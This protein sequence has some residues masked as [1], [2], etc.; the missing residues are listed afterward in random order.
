[1]AYCAPL[2][3]PHSHFT[4]WDPLDQAKAL[5]FQRREAEKCPSC[6]IHPEV[7]DPEH[8]GHPDALRLMSVL[9]RPC[10]IAENSRERFSKD[11][12]AGERQVFRPND[13]P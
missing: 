4:A 3:I 13:D 10:E 12:L 5:A 1:M 2:G 11:R 6:R 7:T 8:G 9:C